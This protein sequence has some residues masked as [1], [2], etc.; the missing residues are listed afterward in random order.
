M[1][2]DDGLRPY[3]IQELSSMGFDEGL[4]SW[5]LDQCEGRPLEDIVMWIFD[6]QHNYSP[7]PATTSVANNYKMVLVVRSDLKMTPGKVAAQCV[8]AALGCVE[9]ANTAVVYQWKS[10][11]EATICLR[12]DTEDELHR[13]KGRADAA[14]VCDVY[15]MKLR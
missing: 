12:C 8:H 14:G 9:I 4:A 10:S 3:L 5:G 13:L 7:V 1:N 6:N 15:Y 2:S 11:G